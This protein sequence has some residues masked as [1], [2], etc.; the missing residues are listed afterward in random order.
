M[1]GGVTGIKQRTLGEEKTWWGGAVLHCSQEALFDTVP[2]DQRL[3]SMTE[4][5]IWIN[6]FLGQM[7]FIIIFFLTYGCLL[8]G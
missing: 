8:L 3:V 7:L 4:P 5:C 2:F 6:A 1:L